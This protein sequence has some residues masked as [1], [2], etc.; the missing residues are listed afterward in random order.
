MCADPGQ[1]TLMC[2]HTTQYICQLLALHTCFRLDFSETYFD[3]HKSKWCAHNYLIWTTSQHNTSFPWFPANVFYTVFRSS[4]ASIH[5]CDLVGMQVDSRFEIWSE[6]YCRCSIH[7][8]CKHMCQLISLLHVCCYESLWPKLACHLTANTHHWVISC[9]ARSISCG[10]ILW[11]HFGD[12]LRGLTLWRPSFVH[13][14]SCLWS[15]FIC[16][17]RCTCYLIMYQS[18]FM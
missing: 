6:L 15:C 9:L 1:P 12:N 17:R 14:D 7:G 2:V 13:S 16:S 10:F 4:T 5:T 18:W 3:T 11:F 8:Y